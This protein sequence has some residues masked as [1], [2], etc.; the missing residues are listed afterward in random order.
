MIIISYMFR[1]SKKKEELKNIITSQNT[2]VDNMKRIIDE[3]KDIIEFQKKQIEELNH[4]L[5]TTLNFSDQCQHCMENAEVIKALEQLVER[6][7]LAHI[8]TLK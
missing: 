4:K 6:K 3:Q 8:E 5:S 2:V 1:K 7:E